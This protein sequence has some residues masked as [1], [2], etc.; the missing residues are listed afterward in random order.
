MEKEM[1]NEAICDNGKSFLVKICDKEGF[2]ESFDFTLDRPGATLTVLCK[3]DLSPESLSGLHDKIIQD[4]L[5]VDCMKN[6]PEE[7]KVNLYASAN[8]VL[9]EQL[10][11][12]PCIY[13]KE[14]NELLMPAP[15]VI[16]Y[17]SAEQITSILTFI[18]SGKEFTVSYEEVDDEV[19]FFVNI[20]GET[21]SIDDIR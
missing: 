1:L 10:S 6:I 3:G 18:D 7:I 14:S 12:D 2:V 4:E 5:I 9:D 17:L 8:I 20:E 15:S 19:K 21:L 11:L 13:F 16:G